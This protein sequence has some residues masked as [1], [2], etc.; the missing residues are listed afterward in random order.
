MKINCLFLY[1]L[2]LLLLF[3]SG[4]CHCFG[5][6]GCSLNSDLSRT[7]WCPN[8]N[9][10]NISEVICKLPWNL[11]TINL[12]NNKISTVPART[13]HRLSPLTNLSLSQNRISS[14]TGGEFEG[15]NE[16]LKLNLSFNNISIL[17][18]TVFKDLPKLLTLDLGENRIQEISPA[19][20]GFLPSLESVDFSLNRIKTLNLR[21]SKRSSLKSLNVLGNHLVQVNVSGL[22]LLESI[23]LSNN[24]H[25]KLQP[26]VFLHSPRLHVLLLQDVDPEVVERLSVET[27][28]GL[29]RFSF[30]LS[31]EE[32]SLSICDLLKG[33]DSLDR[34]DVDLRGSKLPSNYSAF[35]DCPTPTMVV[36]ENGNL[37]DV[38]Q[39][40]LTKNRSKTKI[41]FLNNCGLTDISQTTFKGFEDL[42]TL[43]MNRNRLKIHSGTFTELTALTFLSFDRSRVQELHPEW[44]VPLRN[45]TR[46]S[47][48]KNLITELAPNT[49]SS[50]LSLT[51]LYMQFN[52]LKYITKRPFR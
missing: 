16:L 17:H 43:Q 24:T 7:M 29:I 33:M 5:Y 26:G 4:R 15:L 49:F 22:P 52:L 36:L 47:I 35:L 2:L 34:V 3:L 18:P 46:L 28:R 32:P 9:I 31:L 45:L 27:R 37:G 13:F 39:S 14:L 10:V 50:L 23:N 25:L 8:Q 42:Q 44:F 12:S 1:P 51:E 48:L 20:L 40:Q 38:G 41:L 30:S 11:S 6:K 21:T 19:L